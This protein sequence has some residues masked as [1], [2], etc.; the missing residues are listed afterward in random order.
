MHNVELN[1]YP[2]TKTAKICRE[3]LNS[4][5]A[6]QGRGEEAADVYTN[7]NRRTGGRGNT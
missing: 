7:H 2:F 6:A 3:Q 4:Y 5:E 1:M